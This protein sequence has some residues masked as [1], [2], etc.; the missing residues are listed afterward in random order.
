MFG[1]GSIVAAPWFI[2]V[3]LALAAIVIVGA[4]YLAWHVRGVIAEKEKA[5]AVNAA[6]A[7]IEE[8]LKNER[9][10]RAKFENLADSKLEALLKSIS[11]IH[12]EFKSITTDLAKERASNPQFY[13]QS[14]PEGGLNQW[15]R[16]RELLRSSNP[17]P[18]QP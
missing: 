1:L 11:N 14:L 8:Q 3:K 15:K 16:A 17:Q 13:E 4:G 7:S 18:I 5:E 9:Q 2:Y 6:V 12:T 10:L